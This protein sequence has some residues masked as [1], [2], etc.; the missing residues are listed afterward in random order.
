M[1]QKIMKTDFFH[2]GVPLEPLGVRLWWLNI[3]YTV[4]LKIIQ[5][6]SQSHL[7]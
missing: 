7:A 1:R 2:D 3:D 6:R 4:R 5:D